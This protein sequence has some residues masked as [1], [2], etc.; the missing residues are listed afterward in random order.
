MSDATQLPRIEDFR[1]DLSPEEI[2]AA[3]AQNAAPIAMQAYLQDFP[4]W[5]HMR[6]LTE[7]IQ[8]RQY[9]APDECPLGGWFLIRKLSDPKTNT[10]SPNVD[11]LYGA[12]YVL[13]DKQGP[14]VLTVPPIPGPF[15]LGR[16]P[17]RRTSTRSRS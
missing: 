3:E 13:L 10:V 6:Q 2:R 11:T 8:G 15:L 14:V 5:L 9:M 16:A 1:S 12:S 17:R 4:A 7:F